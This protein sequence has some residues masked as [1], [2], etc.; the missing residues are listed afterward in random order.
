M[1]SI[2]VVDTCVRGRSR[3]CFAHS[4]A[5]TLAACAAR[6]NSTAVAP[7]RVQRLSVPLDH[8]HPH[9][10]QHQ[11]QHQHRH[12]HRTLTTAGAACIDRFNALV[13]K[14]YGKADDK[15]ASLIRAALSTADPKKCPEGSRDA[16]GS[17]VQ[18]CMAKA[19]KAWTD[20]V[21]ACEVMNVA[22]RAGEAEAATARKPSC[23]PDF[24]SVADFM[25]YVGGSGGGSSGG[26]GAKASS[27]AAAGPAAALLA[28]AGALALAL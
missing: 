24:A 9:T 20:F 10:H 26:G 6:G 4:R 8:D 2:E 28:A 25:A 27:A 5:R 13:K 3:A 22:N 16:S 19:P 7:P 12:Q 18:K 21:R 1:F 11:H 15:C 14:E 17:D 23:M